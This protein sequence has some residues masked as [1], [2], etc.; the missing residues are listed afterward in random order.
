MKHMSKFL[1]HKDGRC[2]YACL[3]IE[4]IESDEESIV[5]SDIPYVDFY[6]KEYGEYIDK[7]ILYAYDKHI[8][9]GGEKASFKIINLVETASDTDNGAVKCA[10]VSATW[11]ALGHSEKEIEFIYNDIWDAVINSE[12]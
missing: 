9:N 8:K 11:Q 3:E 2:S 6:K 10:A 12:L 7:G 5:W 4:S 1:K